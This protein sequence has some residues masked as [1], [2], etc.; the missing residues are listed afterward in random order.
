MP[1]ASV[2]LAALVEL[3]EPLR[4]VEQAEPEEQVV[5]EQACQILVEPVVQEEPVV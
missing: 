5:E 3:E 1:L 2:R 4:V